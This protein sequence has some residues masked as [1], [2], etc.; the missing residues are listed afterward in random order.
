M[1]STAAIIVF[2]PRSNPMIFFLTCN[3][4]AE[5]KWRDHVVTMIFF[6][7]P[8]L[9]RVILTEFVAIEPRVCGCMSVCVTST[10]KTN[11][12][13]KIADSNKEI[14]KLRYYNIFSHFIC[15]DLFRNK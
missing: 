13:S 4:C 15:F 5:I 3:I 2:D 8:F 1:V 7:C 6:F 14:R 9:H 10:A 12:Q 11:K